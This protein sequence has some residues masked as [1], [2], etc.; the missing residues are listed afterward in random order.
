M[1]F[2]LTRDQF[3]AAKSRLFSGDFTGDSGRV[4]FNG[5]T[6]EYSYNDPTLLINVLDYGGHFQFLVNS[7]IKDWF[8]S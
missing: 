2:T 6:V 3:I 1:T 4:T 5:V 7:T 8:R